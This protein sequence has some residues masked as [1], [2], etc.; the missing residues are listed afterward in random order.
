MKRGSL[1]KVLLAVV[2][3]II[4]SLAGMYFA[5]VFKSNVEKRA[6][7]IDEWIKCAEE[8]EKA[9]DGPLR[10]RITNIIDYI[11]QSAIVVE[12]AEGTDLAMNDLTSVPNVKHP[13]AVVSIKESDADKSEAWRKLYYNNLSAFT[14]CLTDVPL[15]VLKGDIETSKLFKGIILIH[16][17]SHALDYANGMMKSFSNFNS[18]RAESEYSAYKI[19][20]E[21][22]DNVGGKEYAD[23]VNEK[24]EMIKK[25]GTK[26]CFSYDERLEEIFGKSLSQKEKSIRMLLNLLNIV[27]KANDQ[28]YGEDG[29]RVSIDFLFKLYKE[30]ILH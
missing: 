18:E 9:T 24:I 1:K 16:E 26:G 8:A 23:L 7:D 20:A 19:G 3:I 28:I 10:A 17:G 22:M 2:L 14:L 11:H 21:I 12:P 13:I 29:R 6:A 25:N 5:G 4:V 15:L 30:R 27:F